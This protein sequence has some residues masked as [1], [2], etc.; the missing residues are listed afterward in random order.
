M[1]SCSNRVNELIIFAFQFIRR[2]KRQV[3]CPNL[4][5]SW[6]WELESMI[7]GA[8][9]DAWMIESQETEYVHV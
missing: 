3:I 9:S 4:Q 2:A 5:K 7:F 8:I 6:I 1:Y